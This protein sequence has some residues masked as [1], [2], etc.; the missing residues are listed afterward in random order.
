MDSH[1]VGRGRGG[2]EKA[3]QRVRART[4]VISIETDILFPK[5]EQQLLASVIPGAGYRLIYS[6]YGHD[7]FL[8]EFGQI[9]ALIREF[10]QEELYVPELINNPYKYYGSDN[11]GANV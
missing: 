4:L 11:N 9:A 3:L 5:S 1:D 8:L 7:G 2:L 10:I 6:L